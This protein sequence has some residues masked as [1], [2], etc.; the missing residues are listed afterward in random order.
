MLDRAEAMADQIV[1]WR[2]HVH[3]HPEL[4]FEE[5]E[6]A[7]FVAETLQSF[8]IAVE[9]GVGKTGVVGHLGQGSPC[10]ALRA[11][12]DALPVTEDTGLPFASQNEGVMH[13]CGHD[14]H[15]A[16]LLGAAKLLAETPPERGE[17]RFLFQPSEEGV[18]DEEKSGAI[19][20]VEAGAMVGVDAVVGLHN[21]PEVSAGQ[22]SVSSGP[23]MA[24]AGKYSVRIRGHGGHGALPH[25]TVDPI[26]LAAQAVMAMQTV[27]SRR[28][29]P[30]EAG[31]VTVGTIHAGTK[32]NIIPEYVDMT[33]TM[34]SFSDEIYQQLEKEV[35]RALEVVRALGG[36]F[37]VDFHTHFPVT[38]NDPEVTAFVTQIAED[39]LGAE[40]V[41]PAKPT[42]GGED[43]SILSLE[44]PGCF[45]RLG[46]GCPGKPPRHLHEPDFDVDE[47]AL[48][49]GTA[50]LAETAL[51][52]L[53]G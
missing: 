17:V 7:R 5:V 20:L 44:A 28:L 11:D 9:T 2:R 22:I 37:E 36:D 15:V 26:V 43:F 30:I 32:D 46:S 47:S 27:V 25:Q 42:M 40:A 23:Q 1:R 52:Y 12:M 16:C 18:D 13:A 38:F 50:V 31:V 24:A 14:T 48:P 34:R 53:R 8:G 51:R 35:T 33:G 41:V 6:T 45:L 4:S 19:R 29:E 21:W 49:L 10:I 3:Q 39:L